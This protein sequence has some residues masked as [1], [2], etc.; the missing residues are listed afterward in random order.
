[1]SAFC[2]KLVCSTCLVFSL[3][4]TVPLADAAV[5]EVGVQGG[6][7]LPWVIPIPDIT[8]ASPGSCWMT[9]PFATA[10]SCTTVHCPEVKM[11]SPVV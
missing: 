2:R 7:Q 9:S 3:L 10:T 1:M 11:Q 5:L 4:A 8:K 6:D